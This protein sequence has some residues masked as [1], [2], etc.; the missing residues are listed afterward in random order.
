M[1]ERTQR[2][3]TV[4]HAKLHLNCYAWQDTFTV[5]VTDSETQD[6]LCVEGCNSPD[7]FAAVT[8][9]VGSL[10]YHDKSQRSRDEKL[11]SDLETAIAGVRKAWSEASKQTQ[12]T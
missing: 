7:A 11:L 10:K 9:M 8:Y 1:Q 4:P 2:T 5:T 3:I 6:T 12:S